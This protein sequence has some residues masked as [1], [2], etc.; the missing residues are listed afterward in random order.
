MRALIAFV[1]M[2]AV[3]AVGH[4]APVSIPAFTLSSQGPANILAPKIVGLDYPNNGASIALSGTTMTLTVEPGQWD[5]ASAVLTHNWHTVDAPTIS[6]GAGTSVVLDT[7]AT[8]S[9]VGQA[10]EVDEIATSLA[11][12]STKKTSLWIGPIELTPP[13]ARV[14][15][16]TQIPA[17]TVI[18]WPKAADFAH[19]RQNGHSV[20]PGCD[21]P[22][23][24]PNLDP[25]HVWVFDPINGKTPTAMTALGVAVTA[26]G[27]AGNAFDNLNAFLQSVAGYSGP[28]FGHGRTIQPGDTVL[29]EPGDAT[30]PVGSIISGTPQWSTTDGTPTG[31]PLFTWVMADPAAPSKPVVT[32]DAG[33]HASIY[34][35]NGGKGFIF[36]NLRIEAALVDSIVS[37]IS[38]GSNNAAAPVTDVLFEGMRVSAWQGHSDDPLSKTV[39]PNSGGQS[40]GTAVAASPLIPNSGF[41]DGMVATITMAKGATTFSGASAGLAG[42][43]LWSHGLYRDTIDWLAT[44][45]SGIPAGTKVISVTNGVATIGPCDPVADAATGC[46]PTPIP[47]CD[48][49]TN[50]RGVNYGGCPAGTAP[51]WSGATRDIN[52]ERLQTTEQMKILPPGY[53]N[54]SDWMTAFSAGVS[55]SGG[56][57]AGAN[58]AAPNVFVGT[59]CISLRDSWV[60]DVGNAIQVSNAS[61][62]VLDNNDISFTSADA[63][64]TYSDSG[65]ITIDNRASNPTLIRDHQDAVQMA[66]AGGTGHQILYGNAVINNTFVQQSASDNPFVRQWQ[67]INTTDNIWW[68]T[69]VASNAC[70]ATT[71]GINIDGEYNVV[72]QNTMLGKGISVDNQPK[73]GLTTPLHSLLAN[74]L[75]NGVSR[76]G[77]NEI[78]NLCDPVNGD[79]NTVEG[80]V[81]LPFAPLGSGGNSSVYCTLAGAQYW[82]AAPGAYVGLLTWTQTDFR[83]GIDGVSPLFVSYYSSALGK[84]DGAL[85]LHPNLTF[86]GTSTP[87]VATVQ[88][89]FN[90]PTGVPDGSYGVVISDLPTGSGHH[91]VGVWRSC[92]AGCAG[93]VH[94]TPNWILI[95]SAFNPGIIGAGVDLGPQRPIANNAGEPWPNPPNVGA[96]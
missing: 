57:I 70:I 12:L 45:V 4:A 60:R 2:F 36:K 67:C 61:N 23:P 89:A 19:I 29:V 95:T 84:V 30:H 14:A 44:G 51:P 16:E 93:A 86:A 46:P 54:V 75:G 63:I 90:L 40:D 62:S 10:I 1:C 33:N 76:V 31:P 80:N 27:H 96:F 41:Q 21:I 68:G 35:H 20:A 47:G 11:G 3:S 48:P 73:V 66:D 72:I 37:G 34:M 65:I 92:A 38:V 79:G 18:P 71:N 69:Y 50:V 55:I 81:N 6:L 39:Y 22:P 9:I 13:P 25:A 87:I 32:T 78:P 7:A 77:R 5:D 91:P 15:Y 58:P 64:D 88:T 26:Q 53:W 52:A 8:P 83:S 49:H 82:N 17:P 42:R 43:Y 56:T 24:A 28:L 85:D 59:N 94:D 74:N